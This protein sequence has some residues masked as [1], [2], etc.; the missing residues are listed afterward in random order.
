M[1]DR[2]AAVPGSFRD[3]S[4]FVFER[5][6]RLFRQVNPVHSQHYDLL[7]SSGLYEA[8]TGEGLLVPHREADEPGFTGEAYRVLEPERIA[9]VSNPYEWCFGQ[10]KAAALLTLRVQGL[11]LDRGMSLRDASAFNVQFRGARPVLID[12]LSFERVPQDRPWV[13]YRQFCQHFLAPLALM[14][15]GDPRLNGLFRS[16][17]D[18]VPLDL[19]I[20]LLPRRARFRPSLQLHLFSH[21]RSQARYQ[22]RG[23]VPRGKDRTF[24]PR[25]FRGLLES[26]RSAVRALDWS[27]GR[28]TWSD[29][30][31][32]RE[33]YTDQAFE[34]KLELVEELVAKADPTD[35]WDLGGNVGVFARMASSR[36]V[37]TVCLELDP[38]A[39]ELNYRK[40]V[41]DDDRTL[42]PLVMDL[43]NPS[44]GIGWE[45]RERPSLAER[46]PAELGMAL[47][48]VHHL[49][50]GNNVPLPRVASFLADLCRNLI[51]EFVP[52]ED[53]MVQEMLALR[54]D[55]FPHYT[56]EGFEQAF[57]ERFRIERREEVR[58]SVRTLYLMHGR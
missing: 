40:A 33:S 44:P 7:M 47:A 29:Y 52:K 24:S 19:A 4:G 57:G 54:E 48:L 53:P 39:V 55:V 30:Y 8:L 41:E 14:S 16:F 45:G 37:P 5:D 22:R 56:R 27:P 21:A 49:A 31:K 10:L 1:T 23:G 28:T 9:F 26:L 38:A 3:P 6:G 2:A 13:A 36:G 51:V 35:V 32:D 17:I 43:T 20:A 50:V 25:A 18:G 12:T 46:G 34:H 15:Y 58:D 11:A 42:L